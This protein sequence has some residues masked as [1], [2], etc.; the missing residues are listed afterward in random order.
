MLQR[1]DFIKLASCASLGAA[2]S[3]PGGASAQDLRKLRIIAV[4]TD[5]VKST[6]YAQRAGLFKK[7]GLTVDIAAMSS[8][9]AIFPAVVSGSAD[10]G[11]GSLFP[12]FAA[13]NRGIP[14]RIVAPASFYTS[15]HADSF[16]MVK[17]DSPIHAGRDLN[18]KTFGTDSPK[19]AFSLATRAW[20]DQNGGDGTTLRELELSPT[21]QVAALDA[22]RID[23]VVLKSPFLQ[24]AQATN[25]FRILGRPL[26]AIA[27]HFL[28]SGWVASVDF[29]QK[30]P[31]VVSGYAAA[32]REAAVYT[33]AHQSETTDMVA[34]FTGQDPAVVSRGIRSV[35]ADT[36]TLADIQRPLDFAVK[37]GLVA[38]GFD[39]SLLLA[40]SVPLSKPR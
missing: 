13:F 15:D 18:G 38:K 14:V 40:T 32:M 31:D 10:I 7:R 22:G 26:D 29:I 34:Q 8:G 39:A 2:V 30:N 4:P 37:Y 25:R 6:L 35:T 11:S 21:E 3:A 36:I 9:A 12:V 27:P 23:S 33:N 1:A 19:D 24:Q 5:G 20:M 17:A 16:L 28:L